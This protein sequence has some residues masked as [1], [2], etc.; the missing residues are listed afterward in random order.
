[1]RLVLLRSKEIGLSKM[2]KLWTSVGIIAAL[3]LST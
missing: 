2:S 3:T 1:M